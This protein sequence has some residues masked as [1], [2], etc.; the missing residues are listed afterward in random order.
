LN[1]SDVDYIRLASSYLEGGPR[2]LWTNVYEAYKRANGK[3]EPP[4]PREFFRQT[5]KANYDLRD[6]NQKLTGTSGIVYGWV[7]IRASQS[8]TSISGQQALTDL[9]GHVINEQFKIEKYREGLRHLWLAF[10]TGAR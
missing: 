10:P 5:L 4:N 2:A 3:N 9:A 1:C 6:L 8:I 7:L